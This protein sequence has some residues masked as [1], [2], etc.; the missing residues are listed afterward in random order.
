M[1]AVIRTPAINAKR[2]GQTSAVVNAANARWSNTFT[3][4]A[5]S[6]ATIT[7]AP[8]NASPRGRYGRRVTNQSSAA[9]KKQMIPG[10][11]ST[12]SAQSGRWRQYAS[13]GQFAPVPS[14]IQE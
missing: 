6:S 8:D 5:L 4:F 2:F 13:S 3:H 11:Y 14:C 12:K 9:P 10:K 1:A 7:S